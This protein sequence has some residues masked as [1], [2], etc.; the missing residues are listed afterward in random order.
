MQAPY[1][2]SMLANFQSGEPALA[3]RLKAVAMQLLPPLLASMRERVLSGEMYWRPSAA[4]LHRRLFFGMLV[5]N[6]TASAGTCMSEP[7]LFS[8]HKL[9]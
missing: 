8:P 3:G 4:N 2:I 5:G 7:C 1:L 6:G 9:T